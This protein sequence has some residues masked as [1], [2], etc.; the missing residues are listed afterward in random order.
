MRTIHSAQGATADRI[1]AHLESLHA[2][3]V[4]A[5]AAYVAISR[6]RL[7]DALGIRDG[8]AIAAIAA[9]ELWYQ[10]TKYTYPT[11]ALYCAFVAP[12]CGRLPPPVANPVRAPQRSATD[13]RPA[14]CPPCVG[15]VRCIG[16]EGSEVA[17]ALKGR[18]NLTHQI[19][20]ECT[21]TFL[22]CR[23]LPA[24]VALRD[25]M[26]VTWKHQARQT[27]HLRTR[28]ELTALR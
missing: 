4:D 17:I 26:G 24:I 12:A 16:K 9:I 19:A 14:H 25:R 8:A 18:R 22:K 1:M 11:S 3:T 7:A 23:P 21:A 6:A 27:G 28:T 2:N 10:A 5:R 13:F 15:A 20:T